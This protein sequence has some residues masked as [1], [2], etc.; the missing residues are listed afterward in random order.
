MQE[1]IRNLR[2]EILSE[3]WYSLYK[4]S[5]EYFRS[6]GQ[7]ESHKREV[8]DRGNGAAILLLNPDKGTVILTRQ[9]RMPTFVNGNET[10]MLIEVPAGLLDGLSPEESIKKEVLEETGYQVSEVKKVMESYMSPGAVTEILYLFTAFYDDRMKVGE[11]GGAREETEDIEIIEM[12]LKEAL[13]KIATGEIRDAKT[14]MLLQ[15]A[16]MNLVP[17]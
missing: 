14:I 8:Y 15:Y 12:S 13:E 11:G 4:Y 1:R 9:F 7:W 16:A 10:G 6:D 5:Y 2:K 3:N 17:N